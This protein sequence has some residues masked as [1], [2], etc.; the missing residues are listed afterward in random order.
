V[1]RPRRRAPAHHPFNRRAPRF[2]DLLYTGRGRPG[3]SP[4]SEQRV[5][6]PPA[7]RCGASRRN[8]PSPERVVT[9]RKGKGVRDRVLRLRRPS[10]GCVYREVSPLDIVRMMVENSSSADTPAISR[11][12]SSKSIS[13]LCPLLGLN[14]PTLRMTNCFEAEFSAA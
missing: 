2:V 3:P 12:T 7:Q 10:L 4:R 6:R 13:H 14:N 8:Q 11:Q 5:D 9:P 1:H